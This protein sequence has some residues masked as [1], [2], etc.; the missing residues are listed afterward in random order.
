MLPSHT[1]LKTACK[2]DA[3]QEASTKL[4]NM[5]NKLQDLQPT[6]SW[7]HRTWIKTLDFGKGSKEYVRHYLINGQGDIISLQQNAWMDSAGCIMWL[8]LVV[9]PWASRLGRRPFIVWD[10][11][12]PHHKAAKA[13]AEGQVILA[14]PV[15]FEFLPARCT[16]KLQVMDLVTNAV[17]K[18]AMRKFRLARL[19]NNFQNFRFAYSQVKSEVKPVFQA[20]DIKEV[21]GVIDLLAATHIAFASQAYKDGMKRA[22]VKVGLV[23]LP[24][25]RFEIYPKE[26]ISDRLWVKGVEAFAYEMPHDSFAIDELFD[27]LCLTHYDTTDEL[28]QSEKD[29]DA[30]PNENFEDSSDDEIP[31]RNVRQEPVVAEAAPSVTPAAAVNSTASTSMSFNNCGSVHIGQVTFQSGPPI[32]PARPLRFDDAA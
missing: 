1:I 16:R 31:I 28:L 8:E 7:E 23:K 11:F 18:A 19:Y 27:T 32:Q 26:H 24:S 10:N 29:F 6:A 20:P 4:R 2:D 15:S 13:I 17:L 14:V 30:K 12:D 21:D 9:V 3:R 25:G 22:F 5:C